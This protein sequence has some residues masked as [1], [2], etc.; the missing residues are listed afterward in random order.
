MWIPQETRDIQPLQAGTTDGSEQ[1]DVELRS[2]AK[3]A[4]TLTRCLG[5]SEPP[6]AQLDLHLLSSVLP[7]TK[8]LE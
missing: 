4:S 6:W 5:L 3:E 7:A 1:L 2:Y 8:G